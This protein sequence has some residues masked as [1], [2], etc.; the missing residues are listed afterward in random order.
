MDNG[1]FDD[2]LRRTSLKQIEVLVAL[3]DHSSMS[4]AASALGVSVASVSR[5]SA[6]FETNLGV[7]IFSNGSR[8][9]ELSEPGRDL[10]QS[11]RPLLREI[12]SLR[13]FVEKV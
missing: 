3:H 12:Y 1:E 6:R 13:A 9:F 11:L 10:I 8:R 7:K 4:A 5:M 2:F